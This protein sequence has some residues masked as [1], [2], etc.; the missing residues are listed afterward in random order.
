[1]DFYRGTH[2]EL[3]YAANKTHKL[4]IGIP[5][6]LFIPHVLGCYKASVDG[7]RLS[8]QSCFFF[9]GNCGLTVLVHLKYVIFKH[10]CCLK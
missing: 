10:A 6:R 5:E 8:A 1:M 7:V 9:N 4:G 2:A 3:A